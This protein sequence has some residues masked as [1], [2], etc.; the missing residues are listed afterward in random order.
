MTT[1]FQVG[2]QLCPMQREQFFHRLEFDDDAVFDKKIDSVS[3]IQMN[4]AV[5]DRQPTLVFKVQA[6]Q[7]QLMKQACVIGTFQQPGSECRVHLHGST[8]DLFCHVSM[9][10]KG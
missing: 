8:D 10:H 6:S 1:E 5:H 3:G 4:F 7:R 2:D 9:E